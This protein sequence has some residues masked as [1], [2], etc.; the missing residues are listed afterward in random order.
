MLTKPKLYTKMSPT[1][2]NCRKLCHY[3]SFRNHIIFADQRA[4][5]SGFARSNQGSIPKYVTAGG[6]EARP[7]LPHDNCKKKFRKIFFP[8]LPENLRVLVTHR[9]ELLLTLVLGDL[10]ATLFLEVA[11]I[12]LSCVY[13]RLNGM[14]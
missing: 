3:S 2:Q 4:G 7:E 6:D 11:R 12:E 10:L 8:E 14:I 13:V 1:L 9:L 5:R